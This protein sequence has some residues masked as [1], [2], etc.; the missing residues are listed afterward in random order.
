MPRLSAEEVSLAESVE[1]LA[2]ILAGR[3]AGSVDTC[4]GT[5]DE[6]LEG[7]VEEVQD[8]IPRALVALRGGAVE[9][10]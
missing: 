3:A 7:A 10:S 6:D 8:A 9:G 1:L 4:A 5:A 2:E